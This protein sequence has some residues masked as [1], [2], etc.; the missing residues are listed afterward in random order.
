MLISKDLN[1][2][3]N[4]EIGREFEASHIYASMATFV[5]GLA[6]K[7]LSAL[8]FKQSD[9]ERAHGLK[10]VKYI[11]DTGGTVVIPAIPAQ[12]PISSRSKR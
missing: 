12:R 11:L 10:F 3:I 7:Q 8:L 1:A 9:E 5:D 2:A 4:E 6:L